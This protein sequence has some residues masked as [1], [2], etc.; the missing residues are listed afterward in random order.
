MCDTGSVYFVKCFQILLWFC[1]TSPERAREL[2]P[3]G[4][5]VHLTR[6]QSDII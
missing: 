1:V 4:G 3:N 5:G 6:T 2:N